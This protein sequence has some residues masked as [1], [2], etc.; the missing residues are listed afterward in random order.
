MCEFK[1]DAFFSS[2]F[3]YFISVWVCEECVCQY[4]ARASLLCVCVAMGYDTR[5]KKSALSSSVVAPWLQGH[6]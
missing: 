5:H 3:K 2:E 1:S 6:R 4:S